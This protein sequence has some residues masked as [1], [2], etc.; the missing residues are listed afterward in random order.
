MFSEE[1]LEKYD[2][3][4]DDN[5]ILKEAYIYALK[6]LSIVG[7]HS[8]DTGLVDLGVNSIFIK[9]IND[10]FNDEDEEI[11]KKNIYDII[12]IREDLI[13]K[14]GYVSGKIYNQGDSLL[15]KVVK[16]FYPSKK[17]ES[18]YLH[19]APSWCPTNDEDI[20]ETGV[21]VIRE[22]EENPLKNKLQVIT[23]G[24]L[25]TYEKLKRPDYNKKYRRNLVE[26]MMKVLASTLN[27]ELKEE[28][29]DD[30]IRKIDRK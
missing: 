27:E 19:D 22:M 9:S 8:A 14:V 26:F 1:C 10:F 3:K 16:V 12:D 21:K 28:Q 24:A 7:A 4:K 18:P 30:I 15:K 11:L 6:G 23:F 20:Y 5:R 13:V 25:G 2:I 29:L 17:E